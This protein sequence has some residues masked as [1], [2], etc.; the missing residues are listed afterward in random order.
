M[1]ELSELMQSYEDVLIELKIIDDKAV[2]P[3]HKQ[4]THTHFFLLSLFFFLLV[5]FW[6]F[7]IRTV[8]SLVFFFS[9]DNLALD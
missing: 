9:V 3:E 5:L 1:H 2:T 6:F 4:K 7:S 8:C